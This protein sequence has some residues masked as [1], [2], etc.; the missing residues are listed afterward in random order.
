MR[1]GLARSANELSQVSGSDEGTGIRAR[2]RTAGASL[3]N[4][5]AD[6]AA[7]SAYREQLPQDSA[8]ARGRSALVVRVSDTDRRYGDGSCGIF[9]TE[10]PESRI[11]LAGNVRFHWEPDRAIHREASR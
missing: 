10:H 5:P 3:G 7:G 11:G 1:F 8:G 2:R 6:V 9:R 4:A